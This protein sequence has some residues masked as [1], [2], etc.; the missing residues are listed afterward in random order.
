MAFTEPSYDYS[1]M[2]SL[3]Q[4]DTMFTFPFLCIVQFN[5]TGKIT[6]VKYFLNLRKTNSLYF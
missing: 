5:T 1:Q 3:S 4:S 6:D 2:T